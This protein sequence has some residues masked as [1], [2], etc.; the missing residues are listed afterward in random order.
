MH[1][2]CI[3]SQIITDKMPID[4]AVSP[5]SEMGSPS[6][7]IRISF[8]IIQID[9]HPDITPA[10]LGYMTLGTTSH[11]DSEGEV[12]RTTKLIPGPACQ[13]GSSVKTWGARGASWSKVP[14]AWDASVHLNC[15]IVDSGPC[16]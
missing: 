2:I 8:H 10:F 7:H 1:S 13:K 14:A 4:W 3:R 11:L 6:P 12:G 16:I 15:S 9:T 5:T